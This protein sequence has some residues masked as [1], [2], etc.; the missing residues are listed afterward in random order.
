MCN[1]INVFGRNRIIIPRRRFGRSELFELQQEL[2]GLPD[3]A[4]GPKLSAQSCQG[5]VVRVIHHGLYHM[6][7]DCFGDRTS[8]NV[9]KRA[10]R[11]GRRQQGE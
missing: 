6:Q 4:E 3:V 8:R 9:A 10:Q 1:I 5:S 2:R 11:F 7:H